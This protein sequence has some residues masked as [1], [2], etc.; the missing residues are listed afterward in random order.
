MS[1]AGISK[2]H[3]GELKALNIAMKK[4]QGKNLREVKLISVESLRDKF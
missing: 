4:F 1:K 3:E 2:I